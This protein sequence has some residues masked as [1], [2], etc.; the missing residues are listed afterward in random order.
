[1]V[2]KMCQQL[3]DQLE[4]VWV[5]ADLPVKV[6]A[7]NGFLLGLKRLLVSWGYAKSSI[8]ADLDMVLVRAGDEQIV[9]IKE[10]K[11]VWHPDWSSWSDLINDLNVQ[12]LLTKYEELMSK[13]GGKG[14]GKAS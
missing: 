8:Y 14:K 5:K 12:D 13:S 7:K 6:R 2:H 10:D 1:M 11:L 3:E 9:E 4:D